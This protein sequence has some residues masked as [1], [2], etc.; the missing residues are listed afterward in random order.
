MFKPIRQNKKSNNALVSE[1]EKSQGNFKNQSISV[2]LEKLSYESINKI[3]ELSGIPLL[4]ENKRIV[5]K[6]AINTFDFILSILN[7]EKIDILTLTSYRIGKKT[8]LMLEELINKNRVNKLV[9]LIS[10]NFPRFAPV[11]MEQLTIIS[12]HRNKT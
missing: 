6:K 4:N 12:K 5:T 11:C 1:F 9:L 7:K 2:S 10:Y 8:V 3:N